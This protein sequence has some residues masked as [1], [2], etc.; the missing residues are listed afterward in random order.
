MFI[1]P[2]EVENAQETTAP[3]GIIITNVE[4]KDGTKEIFSKLMYE[5]II[6]EESC[7]LS[8]LRDRRM[9]A[10]A[11]SVLMILR[12]WGIKTSELSYFSTLLN[13]SLIENEKEAM[14][15]LWRSWIPTI[16]DVDDVD[17]IA[18]DRVLRKKD[19][20]FGEFNE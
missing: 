1:G 18:I 3:N 9:R 15:K 5:A 16:Q 11:A 13:T 10:V 17:L 4:Y 2:K 8:A 19:G 12:E 6:S 20:E 14:K 7:D